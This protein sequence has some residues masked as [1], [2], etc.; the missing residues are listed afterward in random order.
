M[1]VGAVLTIMVEF[2]YQ[3]PIND[4]A[5]QAV[6]NGENDVPSRSEQGDRILETPGAS[7][8]SKGPDV[9]RRAESQAECL[10]YHKMFVFGAGED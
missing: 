7:S 3:W 2:K 8:P 10:D 4:N 5:H 1:I 6:R 9:R